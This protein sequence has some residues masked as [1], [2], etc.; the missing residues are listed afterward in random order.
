[1]K[2]SV[3]LRNWQNDHGEILYTNLPKVLSFIFPPPLEGLSI[4]HKCGGDG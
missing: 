3:R 2:K 4:T 1:M